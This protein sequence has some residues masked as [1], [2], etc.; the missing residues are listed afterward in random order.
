MINGNGG[1]LGGDHNRQMTPKIR[2]IGGDGTGKDAIFD[3][4]YFNPSNGPTTEQQRSRLVYL[5]KLGIGRKFAISHSVDGGSSEQKS[6]SF[7][8]PANPSATN[9]VVNGST[10]NP[11]T[12]MPLPRKMKS[13]TKFMTSYNQ[14]IGADKKE[15]KE[16]R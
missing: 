2:R 5:N 4:G 11:D 15:P 10:I 1:D 8:Q 7:A 16:D 13:N 14:E 9:A 3:D 6:Q 12:G